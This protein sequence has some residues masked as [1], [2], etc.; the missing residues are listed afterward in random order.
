MRCT[1]FLISEK[2][3]NVSL[4]R[5]FSGVQVLF[6]PCLAL[7]AT[8]AQEHIRA[9]RKNSWPQYFHHY[10]FQANPINVT[11]MTTGYLST[12][13]TDR[14]KAGTQIL[15]HSVH[16]YIFVAKLIDALGIEQKIENNWK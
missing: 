3:T 6:I 15:L 10:P 8:S 2:N 16:C 7:L 14:T 11:G 13:R 12:L 4:S 1:L 5:C 9:G